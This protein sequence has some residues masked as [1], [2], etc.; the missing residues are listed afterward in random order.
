MGCIKYFMKHDMSFVKDSNPY[1]MEHNY[2]R[3]CMLVG[4]SITNTMP[5]LASQLW[6][7]KIL[8]ILVDQVVLYQYIL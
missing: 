1:K 2:I 7:V 5:T 4:T 6:C 3:L 8:K